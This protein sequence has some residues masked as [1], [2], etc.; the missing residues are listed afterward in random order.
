MSNR[1]YVGNLP[2]QTTESDLQSLFEGSG[3]VRTINIVR[4]RATGRLIPARSID[5]R[6]GSLQID[7]GGRCL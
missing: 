6:A 2:F 7:F 5:R 4:D 1:L 3:Q